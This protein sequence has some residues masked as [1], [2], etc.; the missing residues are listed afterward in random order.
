M[1]RLGVRTVFIYVVFSIPQPH[2][3]TNI[4]MSINTHTY[5]KIHLKEKAPKLIPEVGIGESGGAS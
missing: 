3:H 4:F 1:L 2:I 5:I